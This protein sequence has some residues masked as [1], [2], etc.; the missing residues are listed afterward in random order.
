LSALDLPK[1]SRIG[2][3]AYTCHTVFQAISKAGHIPYFIDIGENY[4]LDLKDLKKKADKIDALIITHMFGIPADF[5]EIKN[6]VPEIPIIEDC[7]HSFLSTYKEKLTGT[8]G[9]ASIFSFG[10][11]KFPSIGKGGYVVINNERIF[12]N[13]RALY[14]QLPSNSMITEIINIHKNFIM[15]I[16]AKRPFYGLLTYSFGKKLDKK[17]DFGNKFSFKEA[18]GLN[19]NISLLFRKFDSFPR[20]YEKQRLNA[21]YIIDNLEGKFEFVRDSKIRKGN[22]FLLPVRIKEGDILIRTFYKHGIEIG[23]HFS[24]SI[25][26]AKNFGYEEGFCPNSEKIVEKIFSIPCH[27]NYPTKNL[28]RIANYLDKYE[29]SRNSLDS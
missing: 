12:R 9:D 15:S 17:F 19:S 21:K 13:F 26:W 5:D 29:I 10:T 3:Q 8:L 22:F 28:I 18:N 16:A 20:Y 27:Y 14:K 25:Q 2:V 7:A 4:T 11:A 24:N 6:I 23:K 1:N